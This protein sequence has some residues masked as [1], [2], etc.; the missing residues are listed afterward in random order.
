M[1]RDPRREG[2]EGAAQKETTG[3]AG[4]RRKEGTVPRTGTSG[5]DQEKATKHQGNLD[6]IIRG[7]TEKRRKAQRA[8]TGTAE[9]ERAGRQ[10]GP[11]VRNG[12]RRTAPAL[13][14]TAEWTQCHGPG[15]SWPGRSHTA[16]G[17]SGLEH[18]GGR[19]G[20]RTRL[21]WNIGERSEWPSIG[22]SG[23]TQGGEGGGGK[24]SRRSVKENK[25]K[26]KERDHVEGRGEE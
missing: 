6:W 12:G 4:R 11:T 8:Q 5:A 26:R 16:M 2:D 19:I 10:Q 24:K 17:P 18:L 21:D 23:A 14:C 7:A 9:E 13:D 20:K 15:H 1:N 22:A 25:S 3:K